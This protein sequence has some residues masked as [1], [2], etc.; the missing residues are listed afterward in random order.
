MKKW[1]TGLS[2]IYRITNTKTGQ[3]YIGQTKSI[4]DRHRSA[5]NY[6]HCTKLYKDIE[7]YGWHSFVRE[8]IEVVPI[9]ELNDKELE[10]IKKEKPFYNVRY[11][12]NSINEIPEEMKR[13]ISETKKQ[14]KTIERKKVQCVETGQIFDSYSDAAEW[15]GAT[16]ISI[17]RAARGIYK[18]AKGHTWKMVE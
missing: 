13:R 7:K 3:F 1:I 10:Y 12:E 16:K 15:C 4:A 17:S 2:C 18:T 6:V 5:K 11:G 8:I 9:D 14:D